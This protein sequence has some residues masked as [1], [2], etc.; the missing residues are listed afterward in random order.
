MS[1]IG[2]PERVTQGRVIALFRDEL[3][4]RFLGDWSDRPGNSN[5][6]QGMLTTWLD[7]RG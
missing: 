7:G 4:Y 5:P 3:K 2:Q 1:T 6:E